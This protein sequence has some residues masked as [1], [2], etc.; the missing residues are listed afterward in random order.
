MTDILFSMNLDIYLTK[1]N[2]SPSLYHD[3]LVVSLLLCFGTSHESIMCRFPAF[4]ISQT[5][6]CLKMA[7]VYN[8]PLILRKT[9][10]YNITT[11]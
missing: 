6:S 9:L 1:D 10:T 5:V 2:D 3:H 7:T 4:P 8:N 11:C